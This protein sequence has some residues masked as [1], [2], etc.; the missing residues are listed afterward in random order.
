MSLHIAPAYQF[1][2]KYNILGRRETVCQI[3]VHVGREDQIQEDV[4]L[5]S[6]RVI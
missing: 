2:R 1:G 6:S 5:D 4:A 3:A